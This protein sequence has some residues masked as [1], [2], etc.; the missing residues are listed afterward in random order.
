MRDDSVDVKI[1]SFEKYLDRKQTKINDNK[2][3][4]DNENDT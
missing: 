1:C 2:K 3:I 4:K